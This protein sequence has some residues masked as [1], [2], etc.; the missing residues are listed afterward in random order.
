MP[1]LK[2]AACK[3]RMESS[4]SPQDTVGG[5]CPRCG[6]PLEQALRLDEVMGFQV[7]SRDPAGSPVGGAG[8]RDLAARIDRVRGGDQA[9]PEPSFDSSR[10]LDDVDGL[11]AEPPAR[12]VALRDPRRV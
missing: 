2:C 10:W 8:Y 12:A 4:Q 1:H 3:G 9:A 5:P 6:S 11:T 7:I